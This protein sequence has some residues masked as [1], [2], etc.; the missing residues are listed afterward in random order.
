[1]GL[2]LVPENTFMPVISDKSGRLPLPSARIYHKR[3][4]FPSLPFRGAI[5][6]ADTTE[7]AESPSEVETRG[8]G[9]CFCHLLLYAIS[10]V[11]P[12]LRETE[13]NA[14]IGCW[15][16][17]SRQEPPCKKEDY[18]S[19]GSFAFAHPPPS[20]CCKNLAWENN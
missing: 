4:G 14:E 5:T 9:S 8:F 19:S 18:V 10:V 16:E 13:G 3:V 20:Q 1:M 2:L 7:R 17:V 6:N 11:S 15:W 12:C